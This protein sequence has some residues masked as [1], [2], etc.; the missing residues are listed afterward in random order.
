MKVDITD[1]TFAFALHV[2]KLCRFRNLE[3]RMGNRELEGI[4]NRKF[5]MQKAEISARNS[6]FP[7]HYSLFAQ[8]KVVR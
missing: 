7:I 2:V 5:R 1:R 8:P 6:T 4:M 3:L